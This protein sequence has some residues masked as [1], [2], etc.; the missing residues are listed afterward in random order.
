MSIKLEL[1]H[2]KRIFSAHAYVNTT[3]VTSHSNNI[4]LMSM[5]LELPH[6]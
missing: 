4:Q 3:R 2:T 6:T 1:P 5:K